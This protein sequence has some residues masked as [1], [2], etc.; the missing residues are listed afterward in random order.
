MNLTHS[1]TSPAFKCGRASNIASD[2]ALSTLHI[3]WT[4]SVLTKPGDIWPIRIL[5]SLEKERSSC[6]QPSQSNQM[7][8]QIYFLFSTKFYSGKFNIIR[9]PKG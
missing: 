8:K 7:L 5:F 2:V 1:A 9:L 3:A 6:L 4:I